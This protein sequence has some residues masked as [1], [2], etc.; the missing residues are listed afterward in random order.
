MTISEA[1]TLAQ[2]QLED[3]TPPQGLDPEDVAVQVEGYVEAVRTA[4]AGNP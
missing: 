2:T 4:I 3:V 1:L